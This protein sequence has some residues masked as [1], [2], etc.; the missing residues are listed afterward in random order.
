MELREM[1]KSLATF[2]ESLLKMALQAFVV[3]AA[4]NQL[5]VATT[6]IVAVLGA[7]GLAVGRLY[8]NAGDGTSSSVVCVVY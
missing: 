6:S 8:R 4:I 7:A 2:L 1:D 5:G 3:I